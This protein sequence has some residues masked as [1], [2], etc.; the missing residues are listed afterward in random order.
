MHATL[1]SRPRAPR[2][3]ASLGVF[4]IATL[5]SGCTRSRLT[6]ASTPAGPVAHQAELWLPDLVSTP[7]AEV[8]ITFS[9]D[10]RRMLWGCIGC[11]GGAGGW[12]ILESVRG[13][14]GSWSTPRHPS[15]NSSANDFDPSFAPDGSGLFFFSNR[16][17]GLGKDDLYFARF[18]SVRQ[19]YD[20]PVNLGP[21]VNSAGDEWVPVL[22]GDGQTLLFATDGRGGAG[23]HDLFTSRRDGSGW[24]P[25]VN[26]TELNTAAEDFDAT[27][28][29]D[30]S[31]VLSSGDFE[32]RVELFLAPFR[33]GH[34][35]P[36]VALG[37]TVNA[38]GADAWTFGPS[39]NPKE[40]DVLYF[41]SHREPGR[42]RTDI[43]RVHLQH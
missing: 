8:R 22:S 43:Y 3:L 13:A 15:F 37:D 33:A 14:D 26:A 2:W 19:D 36:R 39:T 1:P 18:D 5:M 35:G 41:S 20:A 42:G 29:N 32:G 23:K 28:L 7:N 10:G 12:E 16:E 25:A 38:I 31:I 11:A 17:G 21:N 27:I 6:P 4:A 9:P 34:Y 30:G 40:P 24:S